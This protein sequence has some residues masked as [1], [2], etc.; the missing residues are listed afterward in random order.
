LSG[1]FFDGIAAADHSALEN[2]AQHAAPSPKL[3]LKSGTNCFHLITGGAYRTD[4]QACFADEEL[5][6]NLEAIEPPLP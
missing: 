4:F 1:E 2:A 6:A 5:L 3:F